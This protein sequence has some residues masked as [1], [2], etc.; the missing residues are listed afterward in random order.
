MTPTAPT[1]ASRK[2][3]TPHGNLAHVERPHKGA[4]LVSFMVRL[5]EDIRL[6]IWVAVPTLL[7]VMR[8]EV[9]SCLVAT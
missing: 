4:S 1:K 3:G 2:P 5:V 6:V 9:P 7:N 8:V